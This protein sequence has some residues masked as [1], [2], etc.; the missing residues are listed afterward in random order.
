MGSPVSGDDGDDLEAFDAELELQDEAS[1]AESPC[2]DEE[3]QRLIWLDI[4]RH[5]LCSLE[6]T[7]VHRR[8]PLDRMTSCVVPTDRGRL[9][10]A[11]NEG[12]RFVDESGHT[13]DTLATLPLSDGTRTN[14]G[15]CDPHGRLWIGTAD[16]DLE[17][18]AGA[19]F[20]VD[21]EGNVVTLRTG[22]AMSNG[23]DWSPDGRIAYHVDT[24]RGEITRLSL[25][26]VGEIAR[27]D[28]FLRTDMMPDGLTVDREGGVWVAFW[29]RATVN[30]YTVD[31][32]LD[33]IVDV[34]AGHVT[35]CSFGAPSSRRLY[36]TTAR[37]TL[38]EEELCQKP[39]TG[40]LFSIDVGLAGWGPTLFAE[41]AS[42]G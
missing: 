34:E 39:L 16:R 14:D 2:W 29:D 6:M 1:L 41:R 33:V 21:G 35:S 23:I 10:A 5:E 30:R 26:S 38:S 7:R 24:G 9:L 31:G 42:I 12:L 8:F 17:R 13:L 27:S 15:A 20:R 22:L 19:L 32:A 36:I 18:A 11:G 3:R 40:S 25:D 28:V 4:P 37:E